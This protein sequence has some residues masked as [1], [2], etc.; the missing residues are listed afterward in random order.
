MQ[1]NPMLKL[2]PALLVL[3]V[4]AASHATSQPLADTGQAEVPAAEMAER[5]KLATFYHDAMDLREIVNRDIEAAGQGLSEKDFATYTKAVQVHLDY[6]KLEQDSIQA[7]A[8]TFTLPELKALVA[9]YGS[10]EGKSAHSKMPLYIGQIAPEIRKA[11]DASL[12][13]AQYSIAPSR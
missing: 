7:M 1:A 3:L 4:P 13:D 6:V 12:M 10:P 8:Q 9:F 11:I 5:V 2:L